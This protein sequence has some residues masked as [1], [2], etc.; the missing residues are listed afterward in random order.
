[1]CVCV[2]RERVRVSERESERERDADR[3]PERTRGEKRKKT[4]V[5]VQT[6]PLSVPGWP[7]C[8]VVGILQRRTFPTLEKAWHRAE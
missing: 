1:M 4:A 3:K 6:D 7:D 8:P 5:R 2:K